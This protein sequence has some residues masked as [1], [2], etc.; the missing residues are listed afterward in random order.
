MTSIFQTSDLFGL[1]GFGLRREGEEPSQLT[2]EEVLRRGS[3]RIQTE[4][5][6][7][8]LLQ[9]R[10]MTTI[11]NINRSLG[12]YR[13]AEPLLAQSLAIRQREFAGSADAD[14]RL[15]IA[16]SQFNLAWLR[17]DLGDYAQAESLYRQALA[18]RSELLPANDPLILATKFNLAWALADHNS[19]DEAERLFRDVLRARRQTLKPDDRDLLLGE[20]GLAAIL[21][22][23]GKHAEIIKETLPTLRGDVMLKVLSLYELARVQRRLK[24]YDAAVRLHES[25]LQTARDVLPPE[26]PVLA[27]ILVDTAGLLKEQGDYPRAEQAMRKALGIVRRVM[28]GHPKLIEPLREFA[29]QLSARGDFDEAAQLQRESLRISTLRRPTMLDEHVE[30][31]QRAGDVLRR[32]QRY[33]AARQLLEESLKVKPDQ[34]DPIYRETYHVLAL[35][36]RETGEWDR[37]LSLCRELLNDPARPDTVGL[38]IVS[39]ECLLELGQ[40]ADAQRVADELKQSH[41]IDPRSADLGPDS[42]RPA[43]AALA[44]VGD[45]ERAIACARALV[46]WNVKRWPAQHPQTVPDRALFAEIVFSARDAGNAIGFDAA[47][48]QETQQELAENEASCRRKLGDDHPWLARN[49]VAQARLAAARVVSRPRPS[50][51]ATTPSN[52]WQRDFPPIIPG[53]AR[54]VTS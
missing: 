8:P 2:L 21:W 26:H 51:Y 44:A 28:G 36:Y 18:T 22:T 17:H 16:N 15:A 20:V 27:A 47:V 6:G 14:Q 30:I 24:N 43:A 23:Q 52:S 3:D 35:I 39:R 5:R 46:A 4:L 1:G 38:Q 41:A 29:A 50:G 19:P 33:A 49:E 34:D 32:G 11:G 25:I 40:F 7:Q 45:F 13:E 53:C 54:P 48:L 42:L 37:A 31:M 9:A 10:L 12:F